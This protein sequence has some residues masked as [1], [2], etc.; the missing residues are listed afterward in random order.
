MFFDEDDEDEVVEKSNTK[1][2]RKV[3]KTVEPVAKKASKVKIV[4]PKKEVPKSYDVKGNFSLDSE[5]NVLKQSKN[6]VKV[7]KGKKESPKEYSVTFTV[8]VK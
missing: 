3:K 1:P 5:G 7:S 6:I 2:K 4:K 8:K